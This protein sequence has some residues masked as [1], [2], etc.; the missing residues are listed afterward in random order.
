MFKPCK[1]E[2]E[3]PD[4][5]RLFRS[6]CDCPFCNNWDEYDDCYVSPVE[7]LETILRSQNDF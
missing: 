4:Q 7:L 2:K 6:C 1:A 3:I 5:Y